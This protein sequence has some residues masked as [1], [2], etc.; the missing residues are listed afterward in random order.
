[1]DAGFGAM[2]SQVAMNSSYT[3]SPSVIVSDPLRPGTV[4]VVTRSL[5]LEM[6][7]WV[8]TWIPKSVHFTPFQANQS[9]IPHHLTML[10]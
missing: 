6:A 4:C 5:G 1:M 3:Q 10:F 8:S 7:G 9:A 2:H